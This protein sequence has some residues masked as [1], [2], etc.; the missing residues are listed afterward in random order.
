MDIQ[1]ALLPGTLLCA[2]GDL[3]PHV[4]NRTL[5]PQA[6]FIYHNIRFFEWI[7]CSI[8]KGSSHCVSQMVVIGHHPLDLLALLLAPQTP[9]PP[10]RWPLRI[11]GTTRPVPLLPGRDQTGGASVI[12]GLRTQSK[13]STIDTDHLGIGRVRGYFRARVRGVCVPRALRARW[14]TEEPTPQR[15]LSASLEIRSSQAATRRIWASGSIPV[16]PTTGHSCS[17]IS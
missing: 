13:D 7:C 4:H 6:K 1:E 16:K 15:Q 17:N 12:A 3:N 11:H 14:R 2:R 5:A 9:R 10:C 8:P